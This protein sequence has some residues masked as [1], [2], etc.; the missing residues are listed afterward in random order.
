MYVPMADYI[1]VKYPWVLLKDGGE[2]ITLF[3]WIKEIQVTEG[4]DPY[5]FFPDEYASGDKFVGKYLCNDPEIMKHIGPDNNDTAGLLFVR[6]LY[7][8]LTKNSFTLMD[9]GTQ[10]QM[11][12]MSFSSWADFP[13][14][15]KIGTWISAP[16]FSSRN[17][18]F[19]ECEVS[20]FSNQDPNNKRVVSGPIRFADLRGRALRIGFSSEENGKHRLHLAVQEEWEKQLML[21]PSD[22]DL[23]VQVLLIK[24]PTAKNTYTQMRTFPIAKGSS[25]ALCF[26]AG[27][28]G[29]DALAILKDQ[30]AIAET[31]S[32]KLHALL[33]FVGTSYFDHCHRSEMLLSSLHRMPSKTQLRLGLAKLA[34]DTSNGPIVGEPELLFPQVEMQSLHGTQNGGCRFQETSSGVAQLNALLA[35]DR[36]SNEH[37]ILRDIFD[38]PHAISAVKLLQIAH[39]THQER[40][41]SGPGFLHF[42]AKRFADADTLPELARI[43][44]FS[45][46]PG[47]SLRK[48]RDQGYSIWEQLRQL[49]KSEE[50]IYLH[51]TY[52]YMTPGP[53]ENN[54]M[55]A[56][57]V[58]PLNGF[59][60]ITDSSR[61]LN[62][63]FG[64]PLNINTLEEKLN[65]S[66]R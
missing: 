1:Q 59:T 37:Q 52:A 49:F 34:P 31:T 46:L 35:A 41:G 60:L 36:S 3:P 7:E 27:Q 57:I 58:H 20:I 13:R 66:T 21:D 25:A 28:S 19:E 65:L 54:G 29:P 22:I 17:D 2:W 12:K 24:L 8:Q 51:D 33:S 26:Q 4:F 44:H 47:I 6:F 50:N 45:H 55:A 42:T 56:L 14:P 53:I 5:A 16:D 62:G 64:S 43:C 23:T 63:G 38:D 30:I 39:K 32:D 40:E 11:Q 15:L 48:I 18:L 9:A 10:R 61:H